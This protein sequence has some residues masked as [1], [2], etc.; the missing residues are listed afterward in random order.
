MGPLSIYFLSIMPVWVPTFDTVISM[1]N[2]V[3]WKITLTTLAMM[4]PCQMEN[5]SAPRAILG[6]QRVHQSLMLLAANHFVSQVTTSR[7]NQQAK[8][9][10]AKFQTRED[11]KK[12]V[13]YLAEPIAQ[14]RYD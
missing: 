10:T 2:C 5:W 1:Q 4:I 13:V 7:G 8:N 6:A 12:E 14:V 9:V 11:S 3:Q